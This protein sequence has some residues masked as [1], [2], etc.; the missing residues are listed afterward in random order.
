MSGDR[1]GRGGGGW[2]GWAG[3]GNEG[4]LTK[5]GKSEIREMANFLRA[6]K[7]NPA[8]VLSSPLPRAWQ[9]AEIA[10]GFLNLELRAEPDL[11][12]GF[13]S[14]KL[15]K[16]ISRHAG[17]NLM[18]VGHDPGFTNVIRDLTG[19]EVKLAKGG[20]AR[21]DLAEGAERGLLIWLLPPKVAR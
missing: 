20:L 2:P 9:T 17:K 21:I 16:I 13:N 18:I 10:A 1:G 14:A 12:N 5:K 15:R 11:G 7:V 4:P 19:N 3:R 8:L 6:L